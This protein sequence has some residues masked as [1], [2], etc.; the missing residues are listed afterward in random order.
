MGLIDHQGGMEATSIVDWK[1]SWMVGRLAAES[2]L[3]LTQVLPYK[4]SSY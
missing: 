3:L 4:V 2:K 1:R